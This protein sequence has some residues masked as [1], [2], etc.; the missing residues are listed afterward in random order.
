MRRNNDARVVPTMNLNAFVQ[1]KILTHT[2]HEKRAIMS[3]KK[4]CRSEQKN[5]VHAN[6]RPIAFHWCITHLDYAGLHIRIRGTTMCSQNLIVHQ[7]TS[8]KGQPSNRLPIR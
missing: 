4:Q 6:L 2:D 8:K 7:L 3:A 1:K 5:D